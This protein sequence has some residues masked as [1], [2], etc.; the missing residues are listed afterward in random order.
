MGQGMFKVGDLV[1]GRDT[2]PSP[3]SFKY[4]NKP[5]VITEIHKAK[6][7]Q[8]EF[9]EVSYLDGTNNWAYNIDEIVLAKPLI[10]NTILNEI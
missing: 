3:I 1:I 9:C 7:G 2:V 6:G 10:I 5:C 4:D 8:P